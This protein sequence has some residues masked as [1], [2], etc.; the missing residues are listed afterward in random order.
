MH[1][2]I[3]HWVGEGKIVTPLELR[4]TSNDYKVTN[5]LLRITTSYKVEN[6]NAQDAKYKESNTYVPVV[7]WGDKAQIV[8]SKYNEKDI[9]RVVGRLKNSSKTPR[10]S[11][12][13]IVLEDISMIQAAT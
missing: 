12:W 1:K 9:I 2:N 4:T 6:T 11:G 5:F 8:T 13:E 10:K 7:A 3:N